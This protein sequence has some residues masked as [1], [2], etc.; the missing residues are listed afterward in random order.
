MNE[1]AVAAPLVVVVGF[2]L[3]VAFGL[4]AWSRRIAARQ[5]GS[6]FWL[7]AA[8]LPLGGVVV[9]TVGLVWTVSRLI[10]TFQRVGNAIPDEK[11]RL[12]SEGISHALVAS[13]IAVPLC[14]GLYLASFVLCAVEPWRP[15]TSAPAVQDR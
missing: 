15:G 9:A 11:Q 5:G 14:W 6:P 2:H 10:S 8:W 7:K 1:L 13:G 3:L 12:L 4:R